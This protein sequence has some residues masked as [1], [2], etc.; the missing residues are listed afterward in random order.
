MVRLF[1]ARGINAGDKV[2]EKRWRD[3]GEEAA[4]GGIRR[5]SEN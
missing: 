1:G 3:G 4:A 5:R 2:G